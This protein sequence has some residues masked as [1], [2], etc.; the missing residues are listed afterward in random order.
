MPERVTLKIADVRP[1]GGRAKTLYFATDMRILPG[2]FLM[3]ADYGGG[4]KPIS[5][6][7]AENGR[8]GIT[9]KESGP[10]SRRLCGK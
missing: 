3:V 6:S 4:E 10:F 7:E 5:V 8:V 9:V 1:E 2:Q